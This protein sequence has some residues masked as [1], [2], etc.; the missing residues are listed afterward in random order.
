MVSLKSVF[1]LPTRALCGLVESI[2]QLMGVDLSVPD[3]TTISRRLQR[4]E[5]TLPVVPIAGKRHVVV[6][7]TGVKV[8]GE[9]RKAAL[10]LWAS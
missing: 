10:I 5:V 4:L 9:G 2:F 7:S 1:K 8:Y 3:H 6:D